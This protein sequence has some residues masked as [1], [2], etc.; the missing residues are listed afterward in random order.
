MTMRHIS[1]RAALPASPLA[2]KIF[3]RFFEIFW[4]SSKFTTNSLES[5]ICTEFCGI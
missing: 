2:F 3:P 4:N 5:S 1:R